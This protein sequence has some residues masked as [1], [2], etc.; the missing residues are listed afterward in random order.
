MFIS[1]GAYIHPPCQWFWLTWYCQRKYQLTQERN[2]HIWVTFYCYLTGQEM[3]DQ[4]DYSLLSEWYKVSWHCP[5]WRSQTSLPFLYNL[6]KFF[7]VP[8]STSRV[9]RF[10][11]QGVWKSEPMPFFSTENP[12]LYYWRKFL[13]QIQ[14]CGYCL[15]FYHFKDV[16]ALYLD[17]Y[18]LWWKISCYLKHFIS[19]YNM[20]FFP[21]LLSQ[22]FLYF[23][24]LEAWL[25]CVQVW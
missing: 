9:Y 15:L 12:L 10:A 24:L 13:L 18:S 8:F 7:V 16:I 21:Q 11:L 19:E 3:P 6:S 4:G 23:W 2:E 20:R 22:F 5:V 1:S 25:W 14:I 17:V